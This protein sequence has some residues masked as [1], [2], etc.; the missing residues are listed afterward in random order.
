MILFMDARR[1]IMEIFHM[2]ALPHF[3]MRMRRHFA[4]AEAGCRI[5]K[6][7][8]GCRI[9]AAAGSVVASTLTLKHPQTLI[10]H[11]ACRIANTLHEA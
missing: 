8:A 7:A 5:A 9:V 11:A 3:K 2:G 4:P 10:A 6:G 1:L